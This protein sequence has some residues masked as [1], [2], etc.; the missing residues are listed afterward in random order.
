MDFPKACLFDLDG[1]L[2]DT[3]GLHKKAW[4]K[5]ADT[6]GTKLSEE[7]LMQLQGRRR[8]D[9]AKKILEWIKIT[10]SVKHL[11]EVHQ[12]I[13][14]KLMAR[15]R[16]I[17]GASHLIRWCY[18]NDLPTALVTSSSKSSVAYKCGS[19]NWQKLIKTRVYGD[20]LALRKGKP[21]PDPYLL[22]AKKLGIN[23]KLCWAIEDSESGA[24]AASKAGCI[25]RLLNNED[26]IVL[27]ENNIKGLSNIYRIKYLHQF[28][29][30]LEEAKNRTS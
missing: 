15:V 9:C 12:P 10:T 27:N 29:T 5:T 8:V 11:L 13:S 24:N 16:E 23:P 22:A 20:D 18:E 6:F 3:E 21:E 14:K 25:V 28:Q 19:N 26:K 30:K 4:F 7:Q 17:D 1:V 2:L